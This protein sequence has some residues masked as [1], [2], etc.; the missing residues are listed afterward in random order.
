M[1]LLSSILSIKVNK[2]KKPL[3]K[4][5]VANFRGLDFLKQ[6]LFFLV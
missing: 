6:K 5:K 2:L 3:K 1:I 4:A